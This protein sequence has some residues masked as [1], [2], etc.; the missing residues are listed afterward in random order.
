MEMK[1]RSTIATEFILLLCSAASALS[2]TKQAHLDIALEGPWILYEDHAFLNGKNKV[3]VLIAMA[4]GVG[5]DT[6]QYNHHPPVFTMGDGFPIPAGINCVGF[7]TNTNC[8]PKRQKTTLLA[9]DYPGAKL[10]GVSAPVGWTWYTD[11]YRVYGTY[12]ILPMPDSFS[13]DGTWHMRFGSRFDK[14]GNGYGVAVTPQHTI[15]VQLHYNSGPNNLYL[16]HCKTPDDSPNATHCNTPSRALENTGTLRIAMKAIDSNDACDPHVRYAYP[17]MLLLLDKTD[18]NPDTQPK[19]NSNQEIAYIDPVRFVDDSG[20]PSYDDTTYKCFEHDPQKPPT[21]NPSQPA[22]LAMLMNQT[23]VSQLDNI[24]KQIRDL[25]LTD[26]VK[27]PV[28]YCKIQNE[29]ASLHKDSL[30]P[31]LSQLSRLDQLL[32]LSADDAEKLSKSSK[33]KAELEELATNLIHVADSV[34]TKN[35]NDCRAPIMLVQPA[36]GQ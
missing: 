8:A 3:D 35:G 20:N 29:S 32:R 31:T 17:E 24:L 5:D 30:F 25:Q 18:L 26:C 7:D 1:T 14:N 10:L 28:L 27:D 4:P 11:S 2:Q 13:N 34:P 23:L 21:T 33:S 9:G 6:K 36:T 22:S 16:I 19:A 12:L 15:G